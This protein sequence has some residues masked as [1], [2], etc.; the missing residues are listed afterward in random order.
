[1]NQVDLNTLSIPE[2]TKAGLNYYQLRDQLQFKLNETS[3]IIA[4]INQ[5]LDKKN[6]ALKN[7]AEKTKAPA[8][9]DQPIPKK[10]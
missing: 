4:A 8:L 5:L 9:K 3:Q 10:G 2:L 7:E 6:E 1:M